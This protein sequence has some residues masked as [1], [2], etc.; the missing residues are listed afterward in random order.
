MPLNGGSTSPIICKLAVLVERKN[1]IL[2]QVKLLTCKTT[3][4]G[5][6]DWNTLPSFNIFQW[7]ASWACCPICQMGTPAKACNTTEVWKGRETAIAVSLWINILCCWEHL[8]PITWERHDVLEFTMGCPPKW[9]SYSSPEWGGTT[10]SPLESCFPPAS[11][12]CCNALYTQWNIHHWKRGSSLAYLIPSPSLHAW[13]CCF[14]PSIC[15]ERT[16]RLSS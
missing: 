3:L 9:V 2:T 4:V 5:L 13:Q 15:M 12:T 14:L 10:Q 16:T 7:E 1:R 8:S 11:C 6:V